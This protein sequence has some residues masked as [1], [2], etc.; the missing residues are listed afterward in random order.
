MC[1]RKASATKP[2][3]VMDRQQRPMTEMIAMNFTRKP[4][5]TAAMTALLILG[6][7]SSAFAS[8]TTVRSA[9]A[10]PSVTLPSRISCKDLVKLTQSVFDYAKE[11]EAK[12]EDS[13][14][15]RDTGFW[16]ISV[17]DEKGCDYALYT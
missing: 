4:F 12:G 2:F 11:M 17:L 9:P 5:A 10:S 3:I 14:N 6:G 8:S 13:K 16:L 7:T 15:V 1:V